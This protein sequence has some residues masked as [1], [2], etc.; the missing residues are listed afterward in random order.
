MFYFYNSTGVF[1]TCYVYHVGNLKRKGGTLIFVWVSTNRPHLDT[2]L[3]N[4]LR[5]PG[6]HNAHTRPHRS[7]ALRFKTVIVPIRSI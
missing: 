2:T 6:E 4:T 7:D 3:A 5:R 1:L